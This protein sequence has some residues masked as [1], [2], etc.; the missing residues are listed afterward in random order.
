MVTYRTSAAIPYEGLTSTVTTLSSSSA[1][2]KCMFDWML[3]KDETQVSTKEQKIPQRDVLKAEQSAAF[4]SARLL[5]L[6]RLLE[7]IA[8]SRQHGIMPAQ[9]SGWHS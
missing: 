2:V 5:L 3:L 9:Q 6:A 1:I 4:Q 7:A 8:S